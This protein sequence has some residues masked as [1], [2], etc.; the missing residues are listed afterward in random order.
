[1]PS[2]TSS[3]PPPPAGE[4]AASPPGKDATPTPES[5]A[6]P[7]A[8]SSQGAAEPSSPSRRVLTYEE[9][10]QLYVA[11]KKSDFARQSRLTDPADPVYQPHELMQL[12]AEGTA[13]EQERRRRLAE[14]LC[15]DLTALAQE[16]HGVVLRRRV[17]GADERNR[18]VAGQAPLPAAAAPP[19]QPGVVVRVG[20]FV[21]GVVGW[22]V[23]QVGD[24]ILSLLQFAFLGYLIYSQ[25]DGDGSGVLL[26]MGFIAMLAVLRAIVRNFRI[27]HET[28]TVAAPSFLG[29][30]FKPEGQADPVSTPRKLGYMAAKCVEAFILSL[31][32]T[33]SVE[34]LE[35]ELQV[36]DII[37]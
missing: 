7:A 16:R 10:R 33:Y 19:P 36:D 24:N 18:T 30:L 9:F 20:A 22:V 37:H 2:P 29:R 3:P 17:H 13:A 15:A 1:M 8:F 34:R 11:S 21:G 28:G 5:T 35:S 23:Q 26:L 14:E 25:S 31:S 32:P 6:G 12:R 4:A 27:G